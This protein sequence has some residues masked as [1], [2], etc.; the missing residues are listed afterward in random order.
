MYAR[1]GDIF[2]NPFAAFESSFEAQHR[3]T[4]TSMASEKKQAHQDLHYFKF[5]KAYD[6]GHNTAFHQGLHCLLR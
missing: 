4:Q 3:S 1:K 5:P 2:F 6:H